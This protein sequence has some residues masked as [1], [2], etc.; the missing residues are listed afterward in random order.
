GTQ[1]LGV[2]LNLLLHPQCGVER[3]LRMILMRNRSAEDRKNAVAGGLR[4]VAAV[5]MYRIHHQLERGIDDCPSLLRI[6]ILDHLHRA[7]DV[8][9]QSG[10]RFTLAFERG[11]RIGRLW[12]DTNVG[13]G[14]CYRGRLNGIGLRRSKRGTAVTT[15][16]LAGL[17]R[18]SAPRTLRCER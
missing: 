11:H 15:E 12:R 5:M 3:A 18:R 2:V 9:E 16:L 4:D 1:L 7:L 6:K 8:G 17:V 13:P 10:D 14:C